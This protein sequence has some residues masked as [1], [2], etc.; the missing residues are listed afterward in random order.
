MI[1]SRPWVADVLEER[2]LRVGRVRNHGYGR[3][4]KADDWVGGVAVVRA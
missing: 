4:G 3:G 2:G 1:E